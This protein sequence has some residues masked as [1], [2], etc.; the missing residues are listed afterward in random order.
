MQETIIATKTCT[1]CA[2]EFSI[3][4]KDLEFYKKVSPSFNGQKIE[5][6]SPNQCPKCRERRRLAFRNERQLYKRKCDFSGKE[7]ISIYS[8][9]K[10]Y[11]VYDQKI[12]WSDQRDA[13][14]YGR[15]FDFSRTFSEQFE[16]LLRDVP[17]L[18][19]TGVN[20]ENSEYTSRAA[21]NKDCYMAYMTSYSDN[22]YYGTFLQK[23]RDCMDCL[24]VENSDH[25]Y[26]CS[27]I[28]HCNNLHFSTE[29]SNCSYSSYLDFCKWCT[30]CFACHNLRNQEYCIFNKQY[31]KE[32][33]FKIIPTITPEQIQKAKAN[34]QEEETVIRCEDCVG[35]H[36]IDSKNCY[37][38]YNG[39][40]GQDCKYI[41]NFWDLKDAYD[42]S[43]FGHQCSLSIENIAGEQHYHTGSNFACMDAIQ[44][45]WYCMH[46][47]RVKNCF[48][49]IGLKGQE[50]C[51]FNKQYTK[52]EYNELVPKIIE[53]M[54]SVPPLDPL[55]AGGDQASRDSWS[56]QEWP[57]GKVPPCEGGHPSEMREGGKQ[58]WEFFDPQLSPFWYNETVAM[59]YYPL[60]KEEALKLGYK[61]SDYEAPFP[62]VEKFVQWSKLRTASCKTIHEQKPE[63]LEKLLNY[64]VVCEVSGRPFRIIK[65]EID[66]YIK[67][68]LPLPRKHPDIRHQVIQNP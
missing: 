60:T 58:R 29:C 10:P 66:F 24:K 65:Q 2:T 28:D 11:K 44:N 37:Q 51:I 14:D 57:K 20:N 19:L 36:L 38:C 1:V 35:K 39:F 52:E 33:Y 25:C 53:K 64:A 46:C 21:N 27:Y 16:K 6:P 68:N 45:I 48:W 56:N 41:L 54:M 63:L 47:F 17:L 9:D 5:I 3:T 7:I 67:H 13:M 40:D 4:D 62:K 30:H 12:W 55:L 59:E 18:S 43:A 31:T 15:D 8:P 49:C 32:E 50:Y 34:I 22:C 61:R 26:Q 42:C 23:S